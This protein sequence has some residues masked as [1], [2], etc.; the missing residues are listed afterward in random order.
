MDTYA[1]EIGKRIHDKRIELRLTQ[2]ELG[3]AVGMNKSTVQRYETGQVKKI[4]LPVLEAIAKYLGVTPDW[5]AGKSDSETIE[6]EPNAIIL[7]QGKIRM[8]P[9]FEKVSAGLGAY[10]DDC[11]VDYLPCFIQSDSEAER[12]IC[13][14]VC[15]NSMYPKIEDG[16]IIQVLKQ[17]WAESGQIAVVLIDGEDAVVKKI[18]YTSDTVKLISINP[19]WP[20]RTFTGSDRELLTILGVVKKVIK[21]V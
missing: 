21:D 18:E 4:K 2:E 1:I 16:D 15:G 8:I 12:T 19:E 20:P 5:L 14:K 9:V 10:A 11:I 3:L 7:P 6:R 17:D 13:V